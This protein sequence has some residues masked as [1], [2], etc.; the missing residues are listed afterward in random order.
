MRIT[1]LTPYPMFGGGI[2]AVATYAHELMKLG[3]TISVVSAGPRRLPL[4]NQLARVVK[5]AGWHRP[6]PPKSHLDNI[7]GLNRILLNRPTLDRVDDVPDGDV[8]IA[9]WWETAEWAAR[10]PKSKGTGVYFVQHHEVVFNNQPVDRVAATYRLPLRKICCAP[11]LQDLMRT[12]YGDA[13]AE[14]VPYGVDHDLFTAPP[15][16]KGTPMTVGFM[17]SRASFK[18]VGV[19]IRACEI[20]RQTIP[21]LRV[22]TFGELKPTPDSELPLPDWM[23]FE[24]HPAQERIAEIYRSCDAWLFSSNCEGFGLPI[25]E[26]MACRTPVIGT[27]TGVAPAAIGEGGGLLTPIGNAQAMADAIVHFS[28]LPDAA[29]RALSDTAVATAGRFRWDVSARAYEAALLR[30][31]SDVPV[32]VA[33]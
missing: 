24:Q 12:A 29:W 28:R 26:A 13:T 15:R 30:F 3:H 6:P 5:G 2:R 18:D 7:P 20:A 11:W 25:L 4:R 33:R 32:P 14:Y 22:L 23:S 8:V 16:D 19:A 1:F 31:R 27:Q 21:D 17:Y 9:T 10:L